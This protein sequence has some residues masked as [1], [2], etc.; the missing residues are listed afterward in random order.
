MARV[1]AASRPIYRPRA[2]LIEQLKQPAPDAVR[3]LIAEDA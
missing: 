1:R 3:E 2:D